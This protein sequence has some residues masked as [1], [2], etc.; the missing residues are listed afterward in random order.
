[1]TT[2]RM[3]SLFR[4]LLSLLLTFAPLPALAQ[5]QG[6]NTPA[7]QAVNRDAMATVPKVAFEKYT[8]PNGLQV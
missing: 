5:S 8:L 1:M 6:G 7:T 2:S 4:S 3:K